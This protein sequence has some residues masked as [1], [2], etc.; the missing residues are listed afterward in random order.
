MTETVP[1]K[2]IAQLRSG[3]YIVFVHFIDIQTILAAVPL[4]PHNKY[5]Y[6]TAIFFSI[7]Y[8]IYN[9]LQRSEPKNTT[10][11]MIFIALTFIPKSDTANPRLSAHEFYPAKLISRHT[12]H[13]SD[14]GAWRRETNNRIAGE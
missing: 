2:Q 4:S 7:D 12:S 5:I 3:I 10:S 14:S 8:L 13:G 9:K 1:G 11:K 6:N